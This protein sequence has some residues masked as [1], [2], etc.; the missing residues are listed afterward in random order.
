MA[1]VGILP[2]GISNR[3][4]PMT[5]SMQVTSGSDL[6]HTGV[7]SGPKAI[8]FRGA[9]SDWPAIDSL[10]LA[11][12]EEAGGD[13]E[14]NVKS[15]EEG[16]QKIQRISL[17]SYVEQLRKSE[18]G[19]ERTNLYLHDVP[20]FELLPSLRQE[21]GRFPTN[22]LPGWYKEWWHFAQFFLGPDGAT[23]P[24]HFDTL[25]T[26]NIF[27]H[28][29]GLK[30]FTLIP[31]SASAKCSRRDWRWFD[32]D[33]GTTDF[34]RIAEERR[35]PFSRLTLQPGD[36]LYVPPGMLHHVRSIGISM[37]FNIDYHTVRSA[38]AA[39][40]KSFGRAP[41]E[42]LVYIFASLGGLTG[43]KPSRCFEIYS[44]YLN[45]VS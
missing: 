14:I 13:L 35:I 42:N 37:A 21:I 43:I 33:P 30:T 15:F 7:L 27:F 12:F 2:L 36:V 32:L 41:A 1:L 22:A 28:L 10:T 9:I 16:Q 4:K 5:T 34:D 3:V 40:F 25:L 38:T 26:N 24:L 44:P 19:R 17:R 23:T 39:L 11:R 31:H 6:P 8:V 45:Y 29:R 18:C 20:I